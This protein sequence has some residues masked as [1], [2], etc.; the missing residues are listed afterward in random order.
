MAVEDIYMGHLQGAMEK[1]QD[2]FYNYLKQ[3]YPGRS[4]HQSIC[5]EYY[6]EME[7]SGS[8]LECVSVPKI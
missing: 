7:Y 2:F 5:K 3:N 1:S 8:S 4:L 6:R